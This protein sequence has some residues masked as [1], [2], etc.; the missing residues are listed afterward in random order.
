MKTITK[1]KYGEGL[2]WPPLNN[3]HAT[4][5]QKHAGVTEGGWDR[6]RDCMRTLGERDGNNEPLAEGNEDDDDEY[7][8][9]GDIS[10]NNDEY[11]VGVDGVGKPLEEGDDQRCPCT[12]VP[13]ES[14]TEC[15]LTLR[16]SYSQ[17]AALRV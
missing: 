3:L 10:D 9:D 8:K 14:A 12:S 17:W 16:A 6:P 5:N 7:S 11:A 4:I 2:R 15:A 1:I 13:C